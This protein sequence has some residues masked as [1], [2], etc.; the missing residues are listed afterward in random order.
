MWFRDPFS[1]FDKDADFHVSCDFFNGNPFDLRNLPNTGFSYVKSNEKTIQLYKFWYNSSI[2]YPGIH[3]QDAFNKIKFDPF[4]QHL[5]LRIR[6][7]DTAYF[8]GFCQ[9]SRDLNKVCTMHANCCV[10][11]E[12]KVHDIGIMLDDWQK[13]VK[14]IVNQTTEGHKGSW[15]VPQLCRWNRRLGLEWI[16]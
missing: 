13:Y 15:T 2:T 11:L 7:F 12:N 3:D 6:F 16:R 5:G 14:S 8:G 1:Q 10:G 4:I 9:P